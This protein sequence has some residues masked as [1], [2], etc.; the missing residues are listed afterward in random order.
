M[1]T[2]YFNF[3]GGL[4]LRDF[5]FGGY[6][7][8]VLTWCFWNHQPVIFSS[9]KKFST[10][11]ALVPFFSRPFNENYRSLKTVHTVLTKFSTVILHAKM[12]LLAQW[13]QTF[14]TGIWENLVQ[15]WPKNGH[16]WTFFDFL[17]NCPFGFKEIFHNQST[18]Y[19]G[20]TTKLYDL[21]LR[22]IAKIR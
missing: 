16:F 15:K 14:I 5:N 17:K 6:P 21:H 3:T 18:P 13:H 1:I 2:R 4:R 7:L 19:E 22:N 8:G 11:Y 20:P 9:R 10:T 12:L